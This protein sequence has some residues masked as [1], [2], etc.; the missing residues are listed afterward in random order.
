MAFMAAGTAVIM[1]QQGQIGLRALTPQDVK[2]YTLPATIQTSG[3]LANVGVGQPFYLEAMVRSTVAKS[4]ILGVVWA[5]TS[6]P[7]GSAATLEASP[8]PAS[9][10]TYNPADKTYYNVA[11]RMFLRPD[12]VGQYVVTA[13]VDT[14]GGNLV[15][16]RELSGATYMGKSTCALC[17]S[18]G[19]IPDM[20]T[21]WSETG[22]ATA[23]TRKIDGI[24]VDHFVQSCIKCHSV[25]YDTDPVAVNAGFDDVQKTTGWTIPEHLVPGNWDAMPASLKEKGNVQC[26]NCH[27]A[28]SEHAYSLGR[29]DRI[30]L[31]LGAGDCAQCHEAL[32]YHSKAIE[33]ESSRHAITTREPTGETRGGCVRCHSAPGFV[34]YVDGVSSTDPELRKYYEAITCGACHDPHGQGN[35]ALVRKISSVTLADNKTVV[36]NGGLGQLCMNCHMGRRDTAT[37]VETTPGSGNFSPHYGPQTD[38]L[39]GVNAVTYG[40]EIPSSAHK[41]VVENSCVACHLQAVATSS[42]AFGKAGGHTFKP[43]SDNGTPDDASDDIH[44]VG[45]CQSCHGAIDT[46]N[47]KRAD[48]DGN[49]VVEGVQTE[50]HGLLDQLGNLLPPA[51]PDVVTSASF[52]RQQLRA[53]FNWK[54]VKYDGSYGVHNVAYAVGL[55]KASIADLVDDADQDGLS[56][57]WEIASFGGITAY[58]G[59][60]DPDQDGAK[61]SLELSAGTNPMLADSDGDGISDGAELM[62]GSD[63]KNNSDT[64]GFVLKIYTAGEIEF[65]AETGKKYQVQRVSELTGSWVN[66][67]EVVTG[68]NENV[69][70]LTSTRNDAQNYYRVVTVP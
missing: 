64:P 68:A 20:V 59:N 55:L 66:V 11:D 54:F 42:P 43:G 13:T 63:P 4:N 1:A 31:T 33:W 37:Y 7:I 21:P 3:G 56:D 23:L 18:G 69:S 38:M 44:L 61:N 26:E 58:D 48:Y 12:V 29:K 45:A 39:M 10:P 8:L 47:I 41:D 16:T 14:N 53:A 40:K 25:G 2:D 15:L 60:D 62:A 17:H 19:A 35:E 30:S 32:P 28:G 5:L 22:H 27:G 6:K 34:D 46:F 24:G 70:M 9:M 65:F 50:V 51:G 36:T 57:K 52:T 67:G 49:G